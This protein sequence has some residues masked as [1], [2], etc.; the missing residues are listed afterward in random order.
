VINLLPEVMIFLNYENVKISL[1][2]IVTSG[3]NV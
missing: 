2:S 3:T 1:L